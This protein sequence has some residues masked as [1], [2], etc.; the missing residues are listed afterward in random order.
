MFR[1][2]YPETEEFRGLILR[3][4]ED[5]KK[6]KEFWVVA[7]ENRIDYF[8]AKNKVLSNLERSRVTNAIPRNK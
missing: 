2:A 7:F 3:E 6:T 1:R 8:E 4:Y 5:G